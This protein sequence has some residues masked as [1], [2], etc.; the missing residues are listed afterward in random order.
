MPQLSS[1]LE[2]ARAAGVAAGELR[3]AERAL[4]AEEAKA[5][6]RLVLKDARLGKKWREEERMLDLR[7]AVK[8]AK[9]AGARN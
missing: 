7:E 8:E 4:A 6:A 5:K 2:A 3:R 1:A 9:S